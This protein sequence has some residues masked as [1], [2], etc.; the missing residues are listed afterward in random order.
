[1]DHNESA[2]SKEYYETCSSN[3][4]EQK[5]LHSRNENTLNEP[6]KQGT[7]RHVKLYANNPKRK[8]YS[9]NVINE[10]SPE[11][12][13]YKRISSS[14]FEALY[15]NAFSSS[16]YIQNHRKECVEVLKNTLMKD[17]DANKRC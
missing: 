5:S 11:Y 7:K 9:N 12:T 3:M 14:E 4:E 15:N 6:H 17:K 10:S 1:L 2:Q 8:K 16:L 13:N